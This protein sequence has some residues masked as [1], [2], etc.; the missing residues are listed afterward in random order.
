MGFYNSEQLIAYINDFGA[1]AQAIAFILF[2]VQAMAP[3]FP[4][5]IL[6]A[7]GGFLFG[8]QQG[9]FLAWFG[10]LTGACLAYW[11]CLRLGRVSFLTNALTRLGYRES[12][13]NSRLAFWTIVIA[14]IIPVVPTPLINAMAAWGGVSFPTFLAASLIGK[15]PTAILYTGLGMAMFQA[16]DVKTLLY[17]I[18]AGLGII[19]LI[20]YVIRQCCGPT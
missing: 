7:A 17:I 18:G 20:N 3:V 9:F 16:N 8:F 10:A 11:I 2:A 5:V 13:H 15:L 12:E 14:R 1:Y 6:A 19:L 4:Y